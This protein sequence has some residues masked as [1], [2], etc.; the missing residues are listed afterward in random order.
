MNRTVNALV[1][2][3]C[4]LPAGYSPAKNFLLEAGL[5]MARTGARA[6]LAL[7]L[8]AC[9]ATLAVGEL[10]SSLLSGPPAAPAP[11]GLRAGPVQGRA[12]PLS[13]YPELLS[14]EALGQ[15]SC[16]A[17][18]GNLNGYFQFHFVAVDLTVHSGA[19]GKCVAAR[20]VEESSCAHTA[21]EVVSLVVGN[22]YTCSAQGL[23]LSSF[24]FRWAPR[25]LGA[26]FA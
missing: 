17:Q 18:S 6:R 2:V 25:P 24:P 5:M 19:C 15:T 12:S 11:A 14:P 16:G 26:C 3:V 23:Q 20:C 22:C 8:L 7:L 21:K 9:C 10:S 4:R 13:G 1:V